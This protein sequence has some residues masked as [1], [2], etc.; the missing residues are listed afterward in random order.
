M[1]ILTSLQKKF[2]LTFFSSS[3]GNKFF[4]SGGTALSEFY[5]QHRL[6]RDLDFFT[7][8]QGLNFDFVGAEIDKL[9]RALDL[10]TKNQVSSPT[11]LQ[12]IFHYQKKPLKI[13]VIKDVPVHFGKIRKIKGVRVDSLENIALGKL[14]ALFGRTDAK[15]FIDFYFLIKKKN[16]NFDSLFKKAKKKDL[17]LNK[18]YFANM[19]AEVKNL[20]Y[21]P[22]TIKPFDKKDLQRFYLNLSKKL[23][24]K[25]KPKI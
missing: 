10:K 19:I 4:L 2:L 20:K 3:L 17:G 18:F 24:L 7:L 16:L 25:I 22:K 13:D 1:T 9:A 21:F 15:D 12:Y 6:S 5:L 8:D 14:L 11:F 23:F